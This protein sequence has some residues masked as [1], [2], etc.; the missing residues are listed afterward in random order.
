M[1]T[2]VL[3]GIRSGKSR[4]AE[5]AIDTDGAVRY[6]ATGAAPQGD[7]S[8][9]ARIAAH[10]DRRPQA[11]DTVA[12][13]DVAAQLRAAPHTATLVDDLGGWLTAV[14]DRR[15]W[16][17]GSVSDEIDELVSAVEK[18]SALKPSC[19][20]CPKVPKPR[21]TGYLKIGYFSDMRP[22]GCSSTTIWPSGLRTAT[23]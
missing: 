21:K 3:G 16:D 4:W 12:T 20:A 1:R 5:M 14:L 11:W 17:D 9:A 2:L 10:R 19:M 23:Q 15:G 18:F 6:L 22:T 7:P 8:W 13:V